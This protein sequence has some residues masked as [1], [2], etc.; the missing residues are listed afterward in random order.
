MVYNVWESK[1]VIF[2]FEGIEG[3]GPSMDTAQKIAL[4]FLFLILPFLWDAAERG[5]K[6][7]LKK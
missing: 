2:M 4:F 1:I 5:L 6:A 7:I 3:P